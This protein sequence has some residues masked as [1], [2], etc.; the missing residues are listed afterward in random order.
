MYPKIPTKKYLVIYFALILALIQAIPVIAKT[1]YPLSAGLVTG[2][3]E[4][5]PYDLLEPR[6]DYFLYRNETKRGDKTPMTRTGFF[7][8]DIE[9]DKVIDGITFQNQFHR[10]GSTAIGAVAIYVAENEEDS[11][12]DPL[13]LDSYS[14][15]LF[16]GKIEPNDSTAGAMRDKIELPTI[17]RRYFLIEILATNKNRNTIDDPDGPNVGEVWFGDILIEEK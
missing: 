2:L 5:T 7:V 3:R 15:Q 14:I 16:R 6:S 1:W 9:E 17:K 10:N 4:P 12:F 11:S 8:L 13:S